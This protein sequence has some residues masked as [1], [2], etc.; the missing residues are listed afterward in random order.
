MSI[1][2]LLKLKVGAFVRENPEASKDF[3]K[4][5]IDKSAAWFPAHGTFRDFCD[6]AGQMHHSTA[7]ENSEAR[8]VVIL[9]TLGIHP[10]WEWGWSRK[11]G[12]ALVHQ[13]MVLRTDGSPS[14]L[15]VPTGAPVLLQGFLGKYVYPPRKGGTAHDEPD[16]SNHP[17]SDIHACLRYLATGLYSALGLRRPGARPAMPEQE[18]T[19]HGYGS[20]KR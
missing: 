3:A 4:R 12:R 10:S 18:L 19:Y 9:Q 16:E 5:V 8:D 14:M 17:W 6:P 11:D 13:L 15:V 7:S 1:P 20:P 2:L